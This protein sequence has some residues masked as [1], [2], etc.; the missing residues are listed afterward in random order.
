MFFFR[1]ILF[2]SLLP[3]S[4]FS[5]PLSSG[6]PLIFEEING[7]LEIEAEHFRSQNK[8][9]IRSWHI[10]SEHSPSTITPDGDPN[11]AATAS[12]RSYLEILPDTRRSQHDPLIPGENFHDTPGQIAILT[13]KAYFHHPGRYYC[14]IRTHST[15]TEDNSIHL[16]INNTWPESGARMQWTPKSKWH[17][18]SKQRSKKSGRG[19]FGKIWIDV[20]NPGLHEIHFSMREDGC[21]F[22]K[23]ILTKEKPDPAHPPG[24]SKFA[25]K[26][27]P[28]KKPATPDLQQPRQ[29]DGQGAITISGS[30]TQW[31]PVTLTFDGPFAHERDRKPNP[32]IDYRFSVEFTHESGT[33][34]YQVPG[35]FAADGQAGESSAESGTKWRAH[36]SPDQPGKWTYKTHFHG[37]AKVIPPQTGS[38][39]ISATPKNAPGFYQEGRLTYVGKHFLQLAGS[40]R[41]F[42]KAGADAPETLLAYADFDG[43]IARKKHVPLK[44]WS[45]HLQDWNP[46]DPTWKN[47]KGKGLI[48]ALNYLSGK[49]MNAFS[50]L[51]YNAG[52]DGDNVWPFV[53][54]DEKLHYDCSKLDQWNIV[55]T[56]AQSKGLFLHFKLQETEM[57]D[58][59]RGQDNGKRA[60]MRHVP[61]SL[62]GGALGKERKLYL[63]EMIARYSHH[64]ALNWN[65]GEE[66]TQTTAQLKEQAAYIR[67]T[68]PYDHHL[69]VHTYPHSQDIVYRPLLGGDSLTGVSLQNS[70]LRD[71]H[72][73]TVKWHRASN[74]AGTPWAIAFDEP[75]NAQYGM[76]PDPDYPGIPKNFQGPTIHETRT[77]AL[78]GTLMGGGWGVEYYFG[79]KLPQNDLVCEDWR[80]RDQS[81][82]YAHIALQFF[83]NEKV[84]YWE[85]TPAD[86]LVGNS[87]HENWAYCLAKKGYYL[88]FLDGSRSVTLKPYPG[89]SPNKIQWFNTRTGTKQNQQPLPNLE[90]TAP[91]RKDWIAIIQ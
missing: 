89:D 69:V 47:G 44:T 46:G 13:Y 60:K 33:P 37:T 4:L 55:F 65:M 23:F 59:N 15:T 5:K 6:S 19:E 26:T 28:I 79:Y 20:P 12:G 81:W 76:P 78:W 57:D 14:W 48:G 50:F 16:G 3:S 67:K 32:F 24:S 11:H 63:R 54:R 34:T 73:Q 21:E 68:D 1:A 88:I 43:T 27:H 72:K 9:K 25:K 29:E 22:D 45:P 52:G 8:N 82:N 70:R 56:H 75:G 30:N 86:E 66:N 2:L 31:Q 18:D 74:K 7:T 53:S 87:K 64:L 39:I 61:T 85:L 36:L 71:C 91:D 38:F 77:R 51:T 62:D 58:H 10:V 84:P 80:S 40:K 35:Y 41:Y 49:G 42:L 17:W 90:I 83:K